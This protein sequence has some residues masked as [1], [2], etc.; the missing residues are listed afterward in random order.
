MRKKIVVL[1]FVHTLFGGVASVAY[2]LI[3]YQY[4]HNITPILVFMHYDSCVEKAISPNVRKIKIDVSERLG[5]MMLFGMKIG[6]IY[7]KVKSEYPNTDIIVHAHNLQT[8]GYF[9]KISSI[10]MV[11]TLH[12]MHGKFNFRSIVSDCLYR[13]NLSKL[14]KNKKTLI[15]VSKAIARFYD[16]KNKWN[17]GV[18]YNGCNCNGSRNEKNAVFTIAHIG[19]ISYAKG[20]DK[21][22]MAYKMLEKE[23][24]EN[25]RFIIAGKPKTIEKNE[26]EEMINSSDSKHNIKWLGFVDDASKTVYPEVS[27]LLLASLNE[28]LPM[29]IVEAFSYGIPVIATPVGG[30]PEIVKDGVNGFLIH[31]STEMKLRIEQLYND[32]KM[33]DWMSQKAIETYQS[34]LT[35]K[36]M[37]EEYIKCYTQ[38]LNM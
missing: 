13:F 22:F 26:L 1:H 27:V 28:G 5:S 20:F 17:I 9:S 31:N 16:P 14:N 30:I 11:C 10:P 12:S 6:E 2:N 37:N 29:S 18:I 3:N 4:E 21:A 35:T 23:I 15:A 36:I 7:Q 38:L 19:D 25:I 24:R 34:N 32:K 33:Y 8:V